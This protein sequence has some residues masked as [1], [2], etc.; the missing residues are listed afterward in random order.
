MGA[1]ER[2]GLEAHNLGGDASKARDRLSWE[3]QTDGP[4]LM[5]MLVDADRERLGLD[6]HA[7][8]RTGD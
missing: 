1:Q 2:S 3:P 5:R 6:T 8:H 7:E 4:G